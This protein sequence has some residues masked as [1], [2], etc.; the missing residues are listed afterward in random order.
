MYVDY[1]VYF[2]CSPWEA[3]REERVKLS[4]AR[5]RAQRGNLILTYEYASLWNSVSHEIQGKQAVAETGYRQLPLQFICVAAD[6]FYMFARQRKCQVPSLFRDPTS[7]LN[8]D[9]TRRRYIRIYT[10]WSF[11]TI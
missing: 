10:I 4:K 11:Q 5:H 2:E 3:F 7:N 8:A 1:N 9:Y 6:M